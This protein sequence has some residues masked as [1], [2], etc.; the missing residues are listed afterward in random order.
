MYIA[1]ISDMHGH[2]IALQ[3]VLAD[4]QQ[5][6]IDQIVCLGDVATIGFQ[7]K[8]TLELVQSLGCLCLMGNHDAALL[9]PDQAVQYQ[10][11]PLLLPNLAGV[12]S[13][14]SD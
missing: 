1:L 3:A 14:S 8:E 13:I 2:A 12:R 7:P 6:P 11:A 4:I 10:I 9:Q 5:H